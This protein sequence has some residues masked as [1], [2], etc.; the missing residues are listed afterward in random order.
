MT[1]TLATDAGKIVNDLRDFKEDTLDMDVLRRIEDDLDID[2]KMSIMFLMAEDYANAF[3]EIFS[4]FRKAKQGKPYILQEFINHHSKNWKNKLLESL[5]IIQNRQVI[6]KLGILFDDLRNIYLPDVTCCSRNLKTVAKSLYTL[7]EA[8]TDHQT[9]I[10]LKQVKSDSVKQNAD[11]NNVNCLELHLL[12]WLSIHYISIYTDGRAELKN[13]LK[14]VKL[15]DDLE[16]VYTDLKK[17]D[18]NQNVLSCDIIKTSSANTMQSPAVSDKSSAVTI[19]ENI[20]KITNGFCIIISQ[21]IFSGEYETRESSK[22]DA[23]NLK[24]TFEGFGFNV[25]VFESLNE[26]EMLHLLETIAKQFGTAYDCLFVCILSHGSEGNIITKDSREVSLQTLEQKLCCF[27]LKDVIKIIVI[28]ACQGKTTGIRVQT[29]N[30]TTD[31]QSLQSASSINQYKN[32]CMFVSTMQGFVS[33]RHKIEGSWFIQEFCNVLRNRGSE[34]TFFQAY[35][36]IMQSIEKKRGMLHGI[37]SVGQMPELRSCR[38][39]TDFQ[40]PKY[41]PGKHSTHKKTEKL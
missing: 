26:D 36:K 28:Q 33:V 38:L 1:M 6:R 9:E 41:E 5:S 7:C 13:L 3:S 14:H 16:V 27:E 21:I 17:F 29:D 35:Y 24:E 15:F 37:S 10:L 11:L 18:N 25:V 4:L 40:F 34:I 39:H 12:Y 2:D 23:S 32:F 19:T 31:G 30:L 20:R 8:L 22:I